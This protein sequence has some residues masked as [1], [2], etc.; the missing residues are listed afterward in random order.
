MI[1]VIYLQA[2]GTDATVG[3]NTLMAIESLAHLEH[4]KSGFGEA[5]VRV[6]LHRLA[7][8]FA[9]FLHLLRLSILLV[10][11]SGHFVLESDS[12]PLVHY[13]SFTLF[14]QFSYLHVWCGIV[15]FYCSF[16]GGASKVFFSNSDK[17]SLGDQG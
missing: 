13:L 14:S 16:N 1:I 6:L 3:S 15:Q 17:K 2:A 4:K 12:V 5:F 11:L 10:P 7:R 8:F 9:Y